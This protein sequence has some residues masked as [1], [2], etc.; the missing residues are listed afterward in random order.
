[1]FPKFRAIAARSD[2][3][4]YAK[5]A[6]LNDPSQ[7][8]QLSYLPN[9]GGVALLIEGNN[10]VY[11]LSSLHGEDYPTLRTFTLDN[12]YLWLVPPMKGNLGIP[13]LRDHTYGLTWKDPEEPVVGTKLQYYAYHGQ[14]NQKWKLNYTVTSLAATA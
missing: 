5:T 3:Y 9:E 12:S 1:M 8:W 13:T 4:C 2:L 10:V 11:A 6:D 14:D 7:L